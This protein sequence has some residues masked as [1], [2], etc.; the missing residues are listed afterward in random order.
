L[1]KRAMLI[2]MHLFI[3]SRQH[4]DLYDY[5]C[6]RL[7][8]NGCVRVIAD[9]RS[10]ER[11]R[12]AVPAAAQRRRAERRTRPEIDAQLGIHS[13]AIVTLPSETPLAE[14][15]APLRDTLQWVERVQH[16]VTAVRAVLYEHERLQRETEA[17]KQ[18]NARLRAEADRARK[19]LEHIDAQLARAITIAT[20]LFAR[21]EH[22][23]AHR[24]AE[25]SRAAA[26]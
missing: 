8:G 5:L 21:I 22:G 20:D 13:H 11:R 12:R 25:G 1:P 6:E 15:L 2:L 14:T 17:V 4:R 9:R 18:E 7:S 10:G 23:P 24:H 16:H 19:E 26:I 3:V